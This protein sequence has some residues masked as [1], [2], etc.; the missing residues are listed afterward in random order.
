MATAAG[1]LG[2]ALDK[3]GHYRLFPEGGDAT[4]TTIRA[5]HRLIQWAA[6]FG[7]TLAVLALE[8]LHG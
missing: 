8:S 4:T 5:A 3:P 6:C 2:V 1:L 7:L